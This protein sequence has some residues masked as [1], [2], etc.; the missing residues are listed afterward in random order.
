ML[1]MK[2]ILLF[3]RLFFIFSILPLIRNKEEI[4]KNIINQ[5]SS[6]RKGSILYSI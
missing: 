4:G 3:R 6:I 2:N 1:A 5:I